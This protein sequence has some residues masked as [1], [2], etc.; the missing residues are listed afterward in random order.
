MKIRFSWLII[1]ALGLASVWATEPDFSRNIAA[2]VLTQA[3]AE[4][5]LDAEVDPASTNTQPD[6]HAARVRISHCSYQTKASEKKSGH[7]DLVVR[8][9]ETTEGARAQFE[10][11]KVIYRGKEVSGLG[12]AAFRPTTLSQVHVLKGRSY[13]IVTAGASF[14]ADAKLEE[15]A[16][17]E[18]LRRLRD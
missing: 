15:N 18:I 1:V 5:I 13:I 12:E 6:G 7:I 16:A 8:Q 10:S 2:S 17:S 14:K 11:A 4:R 9:S 3:L